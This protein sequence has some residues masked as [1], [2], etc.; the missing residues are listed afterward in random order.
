MKQPDDVRYKSDTGSLVGTEVV[1]LPVVVVVRKPTFDAALREAKDVLHRLQADAGQ[2]G[3]GEPAVDVHDVRCVREPKPG[4]QVEVSGTLVLKWGPDVAGF[5]PRA[6]GLA[7][8]LDL[9]QR[10]CEVTKSGS[11]VAVYT[12]RAGDPEPRAAVK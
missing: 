2:L 3:L 6:E 12:D 10:Y 9:I 11:D 4:A 7:R 5:W 1:R 8:C